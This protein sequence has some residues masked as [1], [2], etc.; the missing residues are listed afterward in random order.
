M[1]KRNDQIVKTLNVHMDQ[2]HFDV[3]WQDLSEKLT[4]K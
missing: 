1:K 4:I 3:T 2:N